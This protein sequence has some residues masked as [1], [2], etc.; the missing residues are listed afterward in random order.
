MTGNSASPPL[1]LKLAEGANDLASLEDDLSRLSVAS[2]LGEDGFPPFEGARIMEK[3]R[4][5]RENLRDAIYYLQ[6]ITR[7]L[8]G[9]ASESKRMPIAPSG[10][11]PPFGDTP[12]AN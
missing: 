12:S 2:Q 11:T 3:V 4:L 6:A 5:C 7:I 1:L 9:L 8:I 10:H